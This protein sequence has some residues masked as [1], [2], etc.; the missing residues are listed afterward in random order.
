MNRRSLWEDPERE[1]LAQRPFDFNLTQASRE[2]AAT[3]ATRP[4]GFSDSDHNPF[5]SARPSIAAQ[6]ISV[7]SS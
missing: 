7:N 5:N 3:P 6:V 4:S 2:N 1:V